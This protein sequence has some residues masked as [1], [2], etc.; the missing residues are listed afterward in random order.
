MAA[1]G[2]GRLAA[3][4]FASW[5]ELC[6]AVSHRLD[7]LTLP[8]L[9]LPALGAPYRHR[10][11]APRD[12]KRLR[13]LLPVAGTKWDS[14]VKSDQ[15]G[16]GPTHARVHVRVCLSLSHCSCWEDM[17]RYWTASFLPFPMIMFSEDRRPWGCVEAMG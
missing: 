2:N 8:Q 14:G 13:A 5:R 1:I 11:V 3:A 15:T 9:M 12:V 4:P 10:T 16:G 7:E 17:G 6:S